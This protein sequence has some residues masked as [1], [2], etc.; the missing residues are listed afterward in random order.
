MSDEDEL[1][2]LSER[3]V[4][5]YEVAKA[6]GVSPSTV[7]RT[8]S[9]PGR[10]SVRTADHVRETAARMG[11]R[12][13]AVF[14][15]VLPKRSR[16]IGFVVSD[17]TNPFYFA[18]LRGA[19]AVAAKAGYTI[20]LMDAQES[21][22]RER[23]NLQKML[24]F[25]DGVLVASSR[26]S[27]T[28]LR[29]V[30]KTHPLVVL[31]RVVTGLTCVVPDAQY[32]MR[33]AIDH[34]KKLG[35]THIHYLSGPDASWM[36]GL[37]WLSVREAA[38]DGS[39]TPHRIGP[40]TPTV[41]GGVAAAREVANREATAVFAYNDLVAM[42]LIHGL[43]ALNLRVPEDVSVIGFDNIF[44]SDLVTPALTTIATPMGKLGDAAVTHII[45]ALSGSRH[46]VS[47]PISVPVKLIVRESTGRRREL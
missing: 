6:A 27:D 13:D 4:T 16:I 1:P 39:F 35:H 3:A 33:R 10:V 12:D 2:G 42:G 15:P 40:I 11:Y 5:I 38:A 29:S 7:S 21:V 18:L 43:R 14:R 45:A 22:D 31:N 36:S 26:M 46:V 25:V 41:E 34:L 47:A 32:G 9:R 8:F 17:V 20:L 37:R 44:A 24:P 19:E 23:K 30:A 28:V